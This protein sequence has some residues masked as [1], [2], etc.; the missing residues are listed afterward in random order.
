MNKKSK[1]YAG[2]CGAK[3]KLTRRLCGCSRRKARST[4]SFHT[5]YNVQATRYIHLSIKSSECNASFINILIDR[6]FEWQVRYM[7]LWFKQANMPGKITR[8]LTANNKDQLAATI[9]T[10]VSP[11]PHVPDDAE[12]T[13]YNKPAAVEQWLREVYTHSISNYSF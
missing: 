3:H 4:S 5:V 6:Y 8:L 7:H 2:S 9:P 11:P 1:V 13:P 10:H 12:Y